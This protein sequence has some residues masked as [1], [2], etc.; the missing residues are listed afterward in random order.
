M[1]GFERVREVLASVDLDDANRAALGLLL[2]HRDGYW[3]RRREFVLIAG[4]GQHLAWQ[5]GS[6]LLALED[7][8]PSDRAVLATALHIVGQ[9]GG[10]EPLAYWWRHLDRLALASVLRAIAVVA[11]AR[12]QV[13]DL[14]DAPLIQPAPVAVPRDKTGLDGPRV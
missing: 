13:S 6:D 4:V 5:S 14:G 10:D 3:L 7:A 12:A 11:G 2:E 9:V 8:A 1:D